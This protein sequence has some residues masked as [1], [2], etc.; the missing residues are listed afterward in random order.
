MA[1]LN[2]HK[3][4]RIRCSIFNAIE[5][6]HVERKMKPNKKGKRGTKIFN[7]VILNV[8]SVLKLIQ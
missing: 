2:V 5:R 6:Y 1:S 4:K 7:R 3:G 8:A